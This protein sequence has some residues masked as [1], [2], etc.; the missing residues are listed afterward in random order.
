MN[1]PCA[2][3]GLM[4]ASLPLLIAPIVVG[5]IRF[6]G[7]ALDQSDSPHF[8]QEIL[9]EEITESSSSPLSES[10]FSCNPSIR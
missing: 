5:N 3:S 9:L 8:G 1:I 4:Y 6:M 2:V 10:G 7:R